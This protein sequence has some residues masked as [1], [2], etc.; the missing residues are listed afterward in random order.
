MVIHPTLMTTHALFVEWHGLLLELQQIVRRSANPLSRAHLAM[1]CKVEADLRTTWCTD[2]PTGPHC[3]ESYA[4]GVACYGN[5]PQFESVIARISSECRDGSEFA[6]I[7]DSMSYFSGMSADRRRHQVHRID[8]LRTALQMGRDVNVLNWMEHYPIAAQTVLNG[9]DALD[10][11]HC[12]NTR[13]AALLAISS[14]PY[15]RTGILLYWDIVD[16]PDSAED[17]LAITD[18]DDDSMADT[19]EITRQ[20]IIRHAMRSDNLRLMGVLQYDL[21]WP[22]E[23]EIPSVRMLECLISKRWGKYGMFRH[24]AWYWPWP[25]V[26]HF[27]ASGGNVKIVG[28]HAH[29]PHSS[30]IFDIPDLDC[31]QYMADNNKVDLEKHWMEVPHHMEAHHAIRIMERWPMLKWNRYMMKNAL[32]SGDIGAVMWMLRR[33]ERY[34][35]EATMSG[36]ICHFTTVDES[37]LMHLYTTRIIALGGTHHCK[38]FVFTGRNL[39]L[40]IEY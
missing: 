3:W 19:K 30:E 23:H 28:P 11:L 25:L 12:F 2:H 8:L 27:M 5:G 33:P 39:F 1:T 17:R 24:P 21:S 38:R 26:Q 10:L 16:N 31:L 18:E 7:I 34:H 13:E 4:K 29:N 40:D 37:L 9:D 35:E 36:S 32:Q 20:Y 6:A 22:V 14:A 15:L